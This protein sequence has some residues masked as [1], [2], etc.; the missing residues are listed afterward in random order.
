MKES[1]REKERWSNKIQRKKTNERHEERTK[2]KTN[3]K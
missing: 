3:A 2:R 1:K